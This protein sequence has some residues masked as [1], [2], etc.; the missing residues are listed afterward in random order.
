MEESFIESVK[1][2]LGD[3]FTEPTERNFR[4]L[5]TFSIEHI[6]NGY[7]AAVAKLNAAAPNRI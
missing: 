1:E 2:C 4:L 5:Y 3:R 7:N 6:S